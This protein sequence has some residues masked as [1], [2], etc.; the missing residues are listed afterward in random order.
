MHGAACTR[1]GCTR[2]LDRTRPAMRKL[3][4]HALGR[5]QLSLH[6]PQKLAVHMHAGRRNLDR[7]NVI[8]HTLRSLLND[9]L[10]ALHFL[11]HLV[12]FKEHVLPELRAAWLSLH[13]KTNWL[14]YMPLSHVQMMENMLSS[15]HDCLGWAG[16]TVRL[17]A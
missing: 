16:L 3:P 12:P 6:S 8:L 9:L 14:P 7:L 11:L 4:L 1:H 2:L 13:A 5:Q 15:R 10:P 17:I